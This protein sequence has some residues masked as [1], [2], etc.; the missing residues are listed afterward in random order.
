[1]SL[2]KNTPAC[3]F[4]FRRD[5]RLSDN[6]A[7]EA[8]LNTGL[9][10]IFVYIF[11]PQEEE[12]WP[13]GAAS[14]VWLHHALKDLSASLESRGA[15]LV[16][17]QGP[18]LETLEDI[19]AKC[20]IKHIF[21]NR[22]YEPEIIKRDSK[23]KEHFKARGIAVST[24]NASLIFEPW[25]IQTAEAKPYKVYSPFAR[26][27]FKTPVN[28][29]SSAVPDKINAASLALQSLRLEEL[30][31]L[32]K[33]PWASSIVSGWKISESAAL[34][35]GANFIAESVLRYD[36]QRNIPSLTKGTSR[37]SPY[38]A[39]GQISPKQLWSKLSKVER[40]ISEQTGT[41]RS[42]SG[43]ETYK[44]EL[45]WRE[46]AY[47]LLYHF[48][49]T[50][51]EPLKPDYRDIPWR[52]DAEGFEAWKKGQTGYPIVDAGM[53]ELWQTGW[54]HNRVRMIVASFLT[55]HL[56]ISWLDGARWFWDT[57]FDAD[58]ASNSLGWQWTAGCGADAQPYFRVFNPQSQAEKFDPQNR[59]IFRWCPELAAG[60]SL[61]PKLR[62]P[63]PIV[64]HK[65]ARARAL[66][67]F[68]S[69]LLAAKESRQSSEP[70]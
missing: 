19:S 23:I 4:W 52:E 27:C 45:L 60:N 24:F 44:K 2:Q 3:L 7:L 66:D 48:P 36:E 68:E 8:A 6:P 69:T 9:K 61:T 11:S 57:L 25:E 15:E 32:P 59:Y 55:K 43:L 12:P 41:K 20:E 50:T 46:F 5:L 29:Q 17:K 54:M 37:L 28:E 49:H 67:A 62:Y 1:M 58:L 10:I 38:L 53:R 26:S 63:A 21:W 47:H 18:S 39:F 14:R 42:T 34:E 40:D 35:Q 30:K 56:L 64:D 16:L 13:M 22:R 65:E 31:L 33:L 70:S 51:L